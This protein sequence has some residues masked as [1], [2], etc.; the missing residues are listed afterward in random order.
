M[1]N[2]N[3]S[4]SLDSQEEYNINFMKQNNLKLFKSFKDIGSA[5]SKPQKD[6][7]FIL[8]SCKNKTIIVFDAS[9]LSR[10]INNFSEIY[11]ICKKNNHN[12]AISSM[13]M[14]FHIKIT[15]NYEILYKLI[16]KS[17]QESID[18]GKRISRSIQFKKQQELPFGQ[19]RDNLGYIINNN[20]EIKILRLIYL[21][22]TK[23]SSLTEI[24]RLLN[25]VGNTNK[26]EPFEI[27]EYDRFSSN[28]INS[29]YLP[30][31]MSNKNI[32]DTLKY[33]EVR[34]RN[35]L[36]NWTFSD[37]EK[38][39]NIYVNDFLYKKD[40][41]EIDELCK[42]INEN[43]LKWFCIWYDPVIGLPPNIKLPEGMELPTVPSMLYIPQ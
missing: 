40:D 3:S 24:K 26:K 18:L 5:F 39:Y 9:R 14:I 16:E 35:K 15:S 32:R 10:N 12:I 13:N 1:L 29:S 43:N 20:H 27:V 21:L 22:N 4:M 41:I 30:Y 6:L 17:H 31:P 28:T 7:K 38:F 25:T 36:L 33:Y 19:T 37:I 23:K 11:K 8:Q 42:D 34:K 2:N